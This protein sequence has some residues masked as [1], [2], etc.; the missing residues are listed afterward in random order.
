MNSRFKVT[1]VLRPRRLAVVDEDDSIR[2]IVWVWMQRA[3]IVKNVYHGWIAYVHNQKPEMI[4]KCPSCNR[5]FNTTGDTE[6]DERVSSVLS[7]KVL[8]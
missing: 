4:E 8:W 1:F 7:T 2:F 3:Y 6:Q 5:P